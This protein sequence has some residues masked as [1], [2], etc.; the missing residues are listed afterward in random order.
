MKN[1]SANQFLVLQFLQMIEDDMFIATFVHGG[2]SPMEDV[3]DDGIDALRYDSNI[4]ILE[5]K[6]PTIFKTNS[7]KGFLILHSKNQ[8][9]I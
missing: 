9:N 7:S 5:D 1:G 6:I 8:V 4:N 3:L 2:E